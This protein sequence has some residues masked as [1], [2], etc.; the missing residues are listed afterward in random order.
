M[1]IQ[2]LDRLTEEV[3]VL[4]ETLAQKEQ[5]LEDLKVSNLFLETLFEGIRE[6][7]MVV[8]GDFIIED[9]NKGLLYNYHVK[10][11]AVVGKKCYEI[12]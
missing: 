9:V 7:I 8:S 5:Q 10:K 4:K 3:K 6:A 11:E 12:N 2:E 1:A